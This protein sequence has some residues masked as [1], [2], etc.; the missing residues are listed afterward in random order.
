LILHSSVPYR[1][2]VDDAEISTR[3][4]P[5]SGY[6]DLPGQHVTVNQ[7]VAWNMANFRKAAG[8]TQEEL[9]ERLGWSAAV[10]S[11]A[12]RSWDANRIRQFTADDVAAIAWA[13]DI[14]IAALFLPPE[15]DGMEHR[16]LTDVPGT[17]TS[18]GNSCWD[19]HTLLKYVISD[20]GDDHHPAMQRYRERYV[21]AM[22]TYL[23][24]D[25]AAERAEY[26]EDLGTEESVVGHLSRLRGQYEALRGILSDNDHLQEALIER[27]QKL[28]RQPRRWGPRHDPDMTD[29]D[30]EADA[31]IGELIAEM[32][33]SVDAELTRGQMDRVVAEARRR[34]YFDAAPDG[35]G[36]SATPSDQTGDARHGG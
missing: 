18:L 4:E 24:A 15:D 14:P 30:R 21:A 2:C 25:F 11:A 9:S 29:A 27:L 26:L 22:N 7:I 23:G 5:G 17:A 1:Q 6:G 34:G 20:P 19:M 3:L 8:Y 35:R 12:E 31:K 32:F 33:G 36:E 16:Y 13:L 10:V 28:R